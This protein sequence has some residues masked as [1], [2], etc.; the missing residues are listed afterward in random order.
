MAKWRKGRATE[1]VETNAIGVPRPNPSNAIVAAAKRLMPGPY[2]DLLIPQE[3]WQ[4][5]AWRQYDICG[6]LRY[7]ATWLGSALS[8]CRLTAVELDDHGDVLGETDNAIVQDLINGFAGSPGKQA[9]LMMSLGPYMTVPGDC[10]I[11]AEVAIDGTFASWC[12]VSNDEIRSSTPGT[13][14]VDNGDGFP[15]QINLSSALVFRIHRPHPRRSFLADS[16]TRASLPILRE[17]EQ[18]TK[19]QF[20]IMDSRLAGAGILLLPNDLDF[21]SPGEDIQPGESPFVA[22]LGQ[23]MMASIK[24][25]GD[26]RAVVPIVVQG[27]KESLGTAQWLIS[28]AASLSAEAADLRDRAIRRLALSLDVPPEILLGLGSTNDWSSSQIEE[29]AIKLH[30]EPILTLICSAFTEGYLKPALVAAGIDPKRYAV[31]FDASR[32]VLRPNRATD[33]KDLYDRGE[34]GGET[35]RYVTGFTEADKPV[36]QEKCVLDLLAVLKASPRA[37][38]A[39]LPVLLQVIGLEKCGIT[40]A[41]LDAAL[42]PVPPPQNGTPPKTQTPDPNAPDTTQA[43]TPGQNGNGGA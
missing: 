32:L 39:L 11:V 33:A 26:A 2:G 3:R 13:I 21:P 43:P 27:P 7:A 28:P 8:R 23:A 5:E 15:R 31:W 16:P 29:S 19:Y 40:Q 34:I 14:T 25:R 20:A 9:E 17:V 4:A 24:D 18:L 30:I 6:E 10:Y 1:P 42:N 35:L 41:D 22:L 37:G 12:V 36:G 38:D